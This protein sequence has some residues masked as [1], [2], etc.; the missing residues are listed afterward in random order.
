MVTVFFEAAG[1]VYTHMTSKR[2]SL[3]GASIVKV[4]KAFLK[5]LK[6]KRPDFEEGSWFL[7][8]DIAIAHNAHQDA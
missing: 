2:S 1:P 4:M 3:N 6:K 5:Q 8:W 7:H